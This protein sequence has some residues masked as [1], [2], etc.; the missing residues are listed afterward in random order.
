[1]TFLHDRTA[2]ALVLV[3]LQAR[4]LPAIM[5]GKAIVRRARLLV[6]AAKALGVPVVLTEQTPGKLGA[7]VPPLADATDRVVVKTRFD[8]SRE[9]A[10]ADALCAHL[11]TLAP[12]AVQ[13]MKKHLRRIARGTLDA[14]ELAADIRRAG[15]SADL[16]EGTR[17]WAEKRA[18]R[19]EGR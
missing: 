15:V 11:A 13:G 4:L 18:P 2:D 19:F 12:L 1:M 14:A 5:R 3:D 9:P 6:R 17:A 7:T 10:L 16:Q 8:A